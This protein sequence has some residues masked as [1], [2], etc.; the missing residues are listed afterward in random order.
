MYVTLNFLSLP[1]EFFDLNGWIP[2]L[3]EMETA[4]KLPP[5][6]TPEDSEAKKAAY[7]RKAKIFMFYVDS[8]LAQAAG[9]DDFGPSV[10]YYK[11]AVDKIE[12]KEWGMDEMHVAVTS[13]T[14]AFALL[15]YN[16]C[17]A[18]WKA[19]LEWRKNNKKRKLPTFKK[20]DPRTH[21][22]HCA[23]WSDSKTGQVKGG[24][25][26]PESVDCFNKYLLQVEKFRRRDGRK[27]HAMHKYAL[28]MIRD[29]YEV[30]ATSHSNKRKRARKEAKP[31]I[32]YADVI[33]WTEGMEIESDEE[34]VSGDDED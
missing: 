17:E 24:G 29:T 7:A 14:E 9:F 19:V 28:N 2:T 32:E 5:A 23:K 11:M 34:T 25:W 1:P 26:A 10:R 27:R 8:F 18:K 15:M 12:L 6:P 31:D 13:P 21:V 16:N 3:E 30:T 22:Y 33:V 4:W 20:E